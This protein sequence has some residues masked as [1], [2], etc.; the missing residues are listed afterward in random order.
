MLQQYVER[1]PLNPPYWHN[2]PASVGL[3]AAAAWR[4]GVP[5]LTE[6]AARKRG[7]KGRVDMQV[8]FP[9]VEDFVEG[10]VVWPQSEREFYL[11]GNALNEAGVD[12]RSIEL[13]RGRR[14]AAVFA[15]PMVRDVEA[16]SVPAEID[17]LCSFVSDQCPHCYA[18]YFPDS[19]RCFKGSLGVSDYP[20]HYQP[21]VALGMRALEDDR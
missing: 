16:V 4:A 18:W 2:E 10:K 7:S 14:I 17:S 5:A 21:G 11:I 12:A 13:D 3:L 8:L 19:L 20:D 6:Y 9:D 1:S 15:G